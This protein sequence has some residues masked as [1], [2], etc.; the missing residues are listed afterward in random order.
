MPHRRVRSRES[1]IELTRAPLIRLGGLASRRVVVAA[2]LMVMAIAVALPASASAGLAPW[3]FGN[4]GPAPGQSNGRWLNWQDAAC[5]AIGD[6]T[7]LGAG[8]DGTAAVVTLH[9]GQLNTALML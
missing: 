7:V 1:V 4:L 5:P 9:G 3:T 2:S 8:W 6:C